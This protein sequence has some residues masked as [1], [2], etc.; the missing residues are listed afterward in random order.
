MHW[1]HV[2]AL[3]LLIPHS[4]LHNKN[5]LVTITMKFFLLCHDNGLSDGDGGGGDSRQAI[6]VLGVEVGVHAMGIGHRGG[7]SVSLLSV[8]LVGVSVEGGV[9]TVGVVVVCH[10][11]A[12]GEGGH[13]RHGRNG[14]LTPLGGGKVGHE[15]L[16]GG[17]NILG[18]I[19]VGS[20]TLM[21]GQSSVLAHLCG[22]K[23]GVERSLGGLHVGGVL[24]GGSGGQDASGEDLKRIHCYINVA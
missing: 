24:E 15:L 13:G 11:K 14:H 17:G 19:K 18:I 10:G 9:D 23:R 16:L 1:H 3:L 6:V 20:G 8:E 22:S 21:R 7:V 12:V 5:A 2:V 4:T